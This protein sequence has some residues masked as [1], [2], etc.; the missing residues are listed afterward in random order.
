MNGLTALT[1]SGNEKRRVKQRTL[2]KLCKFTFQKLDVV[3][4]E[5]LIPDFNVEYFKSNVIKLLTE[6]LQRFQRLVVGAHEPLNVAH[7]LCILFHP[8]QLQIN[9]KDGI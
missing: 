6:S 5:N 4:D 7:V 3:E 8:G 2:S 9:V 1:A